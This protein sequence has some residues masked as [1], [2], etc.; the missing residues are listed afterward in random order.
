MVKV[1]PSEI[2]HHV[3]I[4]PAILVVVAPTTAETVSRVVLGKAGLRRHVA[5]GAIALIAHQ[6]IR[7]AVVRIVIRSWKFVLPSSLIVGVQTE[8]DIEP[9]VAIIIGDGRAGKCAL[10]WSGE[11]KSI[12][13]L[14]ELSLAIIDEEQRPIRPH[15]DDVLP[16]GIFEVGK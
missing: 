13:P 7:R 10:R 2:V 3:E 5:K 15:N 11:L 1:L 16:T 14:S 12:F 4:G 9:A 6:E 8:V